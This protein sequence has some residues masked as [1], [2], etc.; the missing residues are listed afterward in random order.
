MV[1]CDQIVTMVCILAPKSGYR[2][3]AG[4]EPGKVFDLASCL[5]DMGYSLLLSANAFP[6]PFFPFTPFEG[7]GP[8]WYEVSSPPHPSVGSPLP[9]CLLTL[10]SALDLLL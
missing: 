1:L 5:P 8:I 10:L 9:R 3:R 4:E 7:Q 2:A 6:N